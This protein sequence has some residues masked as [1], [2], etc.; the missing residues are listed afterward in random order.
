[1]KWLLVLILSLLVGGG[2]AVVT[3]VAPVLIPMP[4][5]TP[6]VQ[7]RKSFVLLNMPF[8]S[9]SP[10]G[11]WSDPRHQD[12]CEEAAALMAAEWSKCNSNCNRIEKNYAAREIEKIWEWEVENYGSGVDTSVEDTAV[13]IIGKY[14]GV[15][16]YRIVSVSEYQQIRDE[17]EKG[18]LV[19]VPVDGRG[20]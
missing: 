9:Q 16:A 5:P 18:R 19:I 11:E 1:M 2:P 7:V 12:G 14:F 10:N 3:E 4:T 17:I 6:T 20:P 15:S 13:R 8:T